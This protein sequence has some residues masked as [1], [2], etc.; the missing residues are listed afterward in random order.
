MSFPKMFHERA[1][2][3]P[4]RT[5]GHLLRDR[6]PQEL[7]PDAGCITRPL[8]MPCGPFFGPLPGVEPG[9]DCQRDPVVV[10]P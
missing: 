8:P 5:G 3:H 9:L 2:L 4:A 7:V 10:Q 1:A 6:L